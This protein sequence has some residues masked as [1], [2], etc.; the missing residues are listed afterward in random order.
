MH[1]AKYE[2]NGNSPTVT[3]KPPF[4]STVSHIGDPVMDGEAKTDTPNNSDLMPGLQ[5]VE[6]RAQ[7]SSNGENNSETDLCSES[8]SGLATR[9][10]RVTFQRTKTIMTRFKKKVTVRQKADQVKNLS[11]RQQEA[12]VVNETEKRAMRAYLAA[13]EIMTS[14]KT[15]VDVL[16]ILDEFRRSAEETFPE[17][18]SF[19]VYVGGGSVGGQ[20]TFFS[21]IPTLLELNCHL[22]EEFEDRIKNWESRRKIAD[23]LVAKAQFLKIYSTYIEN[24]QQ[25]RTLFEKSIKKFPPF[26]KFLNEFEKRPDCQGLRI[27]SHM[28][29]PIQRIPRYKILLEAYLANQDEGSEDFEDSRKASKIVSSV[30]DANNHSLLAQERRLAMQNLNERVQNKFDLIK[31]GRELLKEARMVNLSIREVPQPWQVVLV[32]DALIFAYLKVKEKDFKRY[33]VFF[34]GC[35]R[36]T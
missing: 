20:K 14:E 7:L 8:G 11:S 22:L 36:R 1:A 17:N 34:S 10:E 27:L 19:R 18:S 6:L 4:R 32:T 5:N 35:L 3:E 25:S 30:A 23:V 28:L 12:V 15:Y 13:E 9:G 33:N 31:P 21:V 26:S 24:F 29:A 16:K 2:A